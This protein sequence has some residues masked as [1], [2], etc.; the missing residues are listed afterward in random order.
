L[1][2][3][4]LQSQEGIHHSTDVSNVE[5]FLTT[6]VASIKRD[7]KAPPRTAHCAQHEQGRIELLLVVYG[8]PP[9]QADALKSNKASV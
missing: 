4:R 3:I 5:H 2:T 9:I 7:T 1:K 8:Q 6:H